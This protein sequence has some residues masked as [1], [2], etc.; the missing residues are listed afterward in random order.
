M[1]HAKAPCTRCGWIRS[2]NS[3]TPAVCVHCRGPHERFDP[4]EERIEWHTDG[5]IKRATVHPPPLR[6]RAA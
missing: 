4:G 3:R 5:L 1:R 2:T 6:R